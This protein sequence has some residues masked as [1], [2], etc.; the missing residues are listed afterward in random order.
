MRSSMR[1][2]GLA[3]LA[4]VLWVGQGAS[5]HAV[6][7]GFSGT[8]DGFDKATAVTRAQDAVA[9]AISD[10]KKAKKIRSVSVSA[11]RATP[12]PYWRS[13]V[14]QE[15]FQKPDIVKSDSYT[16]CWSG[17]VSPYVCT[18]GAKVCW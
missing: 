1:I 2:V 11:M 13:S 18:S 14:S 6:C 4:A 17:V 7:L 16:I 12:Q 8:A 10:Y 3:L 9:Q 5:A 15:L